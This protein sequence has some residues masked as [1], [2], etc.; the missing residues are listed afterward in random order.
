M[1]TEIACDESGYEGEHLI[2]ATTDV[3][4]HASVRLPMEAATG[5]L[6][7][8]RDRIRSPAQEYKS[9]HLL[10]SKH[11]SAL[12]WFLGPSGP[13]LGHALVQLIDKRFFVVGRIVD[14]L[15]GA[16]DSAAPAGDPAARAMAVALHRE[17][18]RTFGPRR[19]DAFLD[20][21]N[22]LLR[23]RNRQGELRSVDSFFQLVEGLRLAAG[24]GPV[25][26]A[27][28]LLGRARPRVEAVRAR[29]LDPGTV[30]AMDPLIPAILRAVARWREDGGPVAVVHDQHTTLTAER[31]AW[32]EELFASAP[33]GRPASLRL[34][35]SRSDA[36][37][38]VAD[39]LA[40]V[41]RKI[42]TDELDRQGDEALTALLRPYVDP[43]S[44]WGDD[45]SWSALR[46]DGAR[47]VAPGATGAGVTR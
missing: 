14:L 20:A 17:G 8:L 44:V 41:A 16:P 7:E 9:G 18:R 46:P 6:R 5:C 12:E 25:A 38:Q 24:Q 32:L 26:D 1:V 15:A 10:R 23:A 19:W 45:R 31:I 33:G 42:A 28:E 37:V 4:A 39:F 30:P 13:I 29:L 3:F 43:W 11:R 35:D 22:D 34:V 40:G 47:P 36:R 2:G 21:C 27:L